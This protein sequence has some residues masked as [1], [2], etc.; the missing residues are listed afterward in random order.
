MSAMGINPVDL[1]FNPAYHNITLTI[2]ISTKLTNNTNN[3]KH[4][5]SHT[6]QDGT[7]V[8]AVP[9]R[10]ET[11]T[12]RDMFK[13]EE[14]FTDYEIKQSCEISNNHYDDRY[15]SINALALQQ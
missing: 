9:E 5:A 14:K 1:P 10:T 3:Q 12:K 15:H 8:V 13:L 6:K 7:H 4:K 11:Y 2:I